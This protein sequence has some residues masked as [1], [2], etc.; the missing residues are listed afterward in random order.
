MKNA[1]RPLSDFRMYS[2]RMTQNI[3][4]VIQDTELYICYVACIIDH[5]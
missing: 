5:G 4:T 1:T 2:S 3:S